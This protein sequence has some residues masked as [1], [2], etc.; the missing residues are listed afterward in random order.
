VRT[1]ISS[2]CALLLAAVLSSQ[3]TAADRFDLVVINHVLIK[4]YMDP[5]L[6]GQGMSFSCG[7]VVNSGT[8]PITTSDIDN[9]Q[10]SAIVTEGYVGWGPY[11]FMM[12]GTGVGL[13]SDLLAGQAV[14]KVFAWND[15]LSSFLTPGEVLRQAAPTGSA[16]TMI[17]GWRTN[18]EGTSRYDMTMNLGGQVVHF[19]E[20]VDVVAVPYE[21]QGVV[22]LGVLRVSSSTVVPALTT[23]WGRI[24]SLYR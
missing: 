22:I 11:H 2:L 4:A 12:L 5:L 6:Y 3:T 1:L 20:Q 15:T 9:A 17:Y 24:K 19:P 7:L 10:Y 21:Q 18:V 14:G 13:E 16:V 8:I 23:S